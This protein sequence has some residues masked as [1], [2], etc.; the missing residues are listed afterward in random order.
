MPARSCLFALAALGLALTAAPVLAQDEEVINRGTPRTPNDFS[1]PAAAAFQ[2]GRDNGN[3]NREYLDH[4]AKTHGPQRSAAAIEADARELLTAA[5]LACQTTASAELGVTRNRRQIYEVDCASGPGY[6]L[7]EGTPP[8]T[9][10][11][12]QLSAEAARRRAADPRADVGSQCA[13]PGNAE[14]TLYAEFARTAGLVCTV[15]AGAWIGRPEA[16]GDRYEIGCSDGDGGWVDVAA[17][18]S[19]KL[20]AEC[21]EVVSVGQAC[22]LT[23]G[24]EQAAALQARLAGTALDQC[25]PQAARYVGGNASGRFYEVKCADGQGAMARFDAAGA[26]ARSYAC[27]EAGQIGDGCKL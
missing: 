2:A 26:F 6:I 9:F 12:L 17:D 7:V 15:D 10:G 24:Q 14:T 20:S 11:C 21:L 4:A 19:A 18:G 8:Q 25:R 27:A 13:L 22:P 16:G 5:G 3:F 23:T 1:S